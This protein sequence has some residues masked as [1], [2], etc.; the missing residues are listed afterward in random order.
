MAVGENIKL[1]RV[2]GNI[3]AIGKKKNKTIFYYKKQVIFVKKK[4]KSSFHPY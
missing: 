1:G 4:K 3:K 2:E